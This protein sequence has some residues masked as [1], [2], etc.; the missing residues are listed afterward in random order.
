MTRELLLPDLM[1]AAKDTS[2]EASIAWLVQTILATLL[3]DKMEEWIRQVGFGDDIDMLKSEIRR[4]EIVAD[5]VIGRA[6]E[7]KTLARSL[8]RVNELLYETD[9]VVDELDYCRLQQQI[10]GVTWDEPEGVYGAERVDDISIGDADTPVNSSVGKLRS[11]VWEHFTI[12]EKD[13]GKPV[14]SVCRYCAKEF[15]CKTKN[16][17]SS[18]NKHVNKICTKKPR[19]H[20]LVLSS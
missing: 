2:P 9:D 3:M 19:A 15:T 10:E 13:N 6:A 17:T 16:G 11:V 8:A 1:E 20:P 5:A 14:K 7:N 12:T 4:V 18:M